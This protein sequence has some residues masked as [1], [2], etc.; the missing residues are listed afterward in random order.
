MRGMLM[1]AH[2]NDLFDYG[3]MAYASALSAIH[4]IDKPISIVTDE[5]TWEKLLRE[6]PRAMFTFDHA[7]LIDHENTHQRHFD[8]ADGS[9]K[10]AKYHNTS[11]LDAYAL[12][13]YDETLLIDTD[14]LIQDT[15]LQ[16]V[17]GSSA[18]VRMNHEISELNSS[19]GNTQIK[20]SDNSLT[21]FWATICYFRKCK[22]TEDFFALSKYVEH[23]YEYY[24]SLH[25]FPTSIVRVD[26]IMT[27]AAHIMSGYVSGAKTVVE[28][29]PVEDTVFAWNKDIMIDFDEDRT[30]FLTKSGGRHFPVSTYRTVH[31]MNKDSMMNMADRI[32]DTYAIL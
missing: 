4:H 30:T 17:W 21:T 3:K 13:P 25:G 32:I 2:N 12:S 20:L 11:R 10:K 24:G 18:Y 1:F 6:Y 16:H 9:T 7:I 29:L 14:V 23:H 28:P 31:C 22:V 26:Y 8:L 5:S 27:I 19:E 15:S